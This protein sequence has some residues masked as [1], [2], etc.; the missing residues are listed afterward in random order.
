MHACMSFAMHVRMYVCTYVLY[1]YPDDYQ[2]RTTF[3]TQIRDYQTR[4]TFVTQIRDYQTRT[5][6]V[7]QI[8][9]YQTRTTFVT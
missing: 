4:T 2:T 9:D 6:F 5:T 3:V 7:T 1:S 8:R